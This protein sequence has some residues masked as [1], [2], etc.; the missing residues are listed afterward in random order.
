MIPAHKYQQDVFSRI[1]GYGYI[2]VS[3]FFMLSGFIL[4]IVYLRPGKS[5][6]RRR[7]FLSRFARIYPLY[8]A[9]ILLDLPHFLHVQRSVTHAP[10]SQTIG[11]IVA[12][13]TLTQAW[14]PN[15]HGLDNPSW[16]LSAEAFFYLLFPFFGA[17]MIRLSLRA[18]LLLSVVVYTLGIALVQSFHP[19]GQTY[20]PL[21]HLFVFIL[22][23]ALA[24]FYIWMGKR[25][26]HALRL[27]RTAPWMLLA[28]VGAI[29]AIPALR[30][31]IPEIQLQHGIAAPFFAL[32]ILALASGNRFIVRPLSPNWLV[33]LGEASFA[34]YLIH[35][36]IAAILRSSIERHGTPMLL[37]YL[38]VCVS[39]SV[40]S[41]YFLEIPMRFWILSK[42][43]IRSP[44]TQVTSAIAQ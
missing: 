41:L 38:L 31:P 10:L 37:V 14:F 11:T 4:A 19:S 17:Q 5:V 2:S 44:E 35:Q 32:V 34:L 29:L 24:R 12:T 42:E 33:T 36:P 22:G 43:R 30:I 20:S 27:Q 15:L 9:A 6:Q 39:L 16:S 7:F 28:G 40:L 25:P 3:F 21:P 23:I 1:L 26:E 8:L 13:L 18:T